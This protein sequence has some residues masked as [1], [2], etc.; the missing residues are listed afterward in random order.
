[1]AAVQSYRY[2]AR[3][4]TLFSASSVACKSNVRTISSQ[5]GRSSSNPL[6]LHTESAT[7]HLLGTMHIAEASAE[8]A[9][10]LIIHEHGKGTLGAVFLE[11]DSA[12]F[13]RLKASKSP[14]ESL[15]AHALS[16]LSRPGRTPLASILELGVSS[17]YRFLHRLGFASGV[18]FKAAIEIAEELNVPILLG[19]QDI[20]ITMKRLAEGFRNDFDLPRLLSLMMS[21][22][23]KRNESPAEQSLREAFQAIA[24]GD[25]KNA[26]EKLTKLI[27]Q[28]TVREM[29]KPMKTFAPNVTRALLHE[30][31]VVMT[32]NILKYVDEL[33]Q[34]KRN[35]VAVV[36]L[37]HVEGIAEEWKHR[38]FRSD[39]A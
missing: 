39:A 31:D 11:L 23:T 1:M 34:G 14:D 38:H 5:A 4:R 7:V 19:D 35:M 37:A 20:Q 15:L 29:M 8:A 36:G 25:A 13:S 6:R 26:Q 17:M 16:V 9:R 22:S 24:A 32:N 28:D 21:R 2:L 27:D 18:E 10:H 12:R 3:Y 33:P 30:R